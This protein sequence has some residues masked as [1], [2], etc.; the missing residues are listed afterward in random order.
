MGLLEARQRQQRRRLSRRRR[1]DARRQ[2]TSSVFF[3]RARQGPD[4]IIIVRGGMGAVE[5]S[6]DGAKAP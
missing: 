3:R 4:C 2:F 6:I 1:L 5:E